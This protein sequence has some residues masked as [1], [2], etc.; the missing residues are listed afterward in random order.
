[1]KKETKTAEKKP[2]LS[3]Y[4][5]MD[6]SKKTALW[7]IIFLLPWLIGLV[8]FFLRP[9]VNT[10]WYSL[11]SMEM[12]N[13]KFS[14][15]F[16][17]VDN[18]KYV[19]GVNA[20]YTRYLAESFTN[21]AKEVPFQ[22]FLALF[23]AML[24]NGEYRGRGFFRA[25]FVIPIILATGVATFEL[26]EVKM[27]TAT[28]ESVMDMKWLEDLI[29]NSGIPQQLTS[30]LVT[31]VQNIFKVVTTC[32]VQILLF[33]SGLQAISPTLYEV[34][35]MEGCTQFETFCKITL[36][37]VSPTILVCLVYSIAESFASA[38]ITVGD[39]T[40]SFSSYIQSITFNGSP[41]YYGYG[42]AMSFIYFAATLVT[43]G[44]V[45][46]IVSKGVFYY[47]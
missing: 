3:W 31:Y 7:G 33:L 17:G 11:C 42:A 29:V 25:I 47:D 44:V 9:L 30:L 45:C 38:T 12:V 6:F 21:M 24:L 41:E 37:M 40:Q 13:G 4:K 1:M 32:G 27:S 14:G 19:L 8:F 10:L 36:P 20:N 46:G 23:I 28:T 18:F 35:K 5:R 39:S 34:A 15:T 26:A 43:V 2:T 16:I 22:I